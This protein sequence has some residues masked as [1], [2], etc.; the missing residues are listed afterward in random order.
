[1]TC[2]CADVSAS[3]CV[4]EQ[5]PVEH[6]EAVPRED[7]LLEWHYVVTGPAGSPYE[8]FLSLGDSTRMIQRADR[9]A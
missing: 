7:N 6:I 3:A 1:M 9:R 4:I 8:G 2:V 5:E